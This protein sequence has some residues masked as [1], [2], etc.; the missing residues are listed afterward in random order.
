[1]AIE[2]PMQILLKFSMMAVGILPL[3]GESDKKTNR[4][5]LGIGV[6]WF[7]SV[8]T[9][10]SI[11]SVLTGARWIVEPVSEETHSLIGKLTF[12]PIFFYRMIVCFFV[13]ITLTSMSV[14]AFIL[15]TLIT[16]IVLICVQDEY[17]NQ[18]GKHALL[19]LI[20]PIPNLP[21]DE[22]IK[23]EH[24][25]RLKTLFW[26]VLTGNSMFLILHSLIYC[27]YHFDVFNPWIYNCELNVLII[28]EQV[29]KNINPLMITL[30]V[31]ATVPVLLSY[32]LPSKG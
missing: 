29:Y 17:D 23:S 6:G 18:P 22:K 2:A 4:N 31:G 12:V 5:G 16:W 24:N 7:Q 28:K 32:C 3:P 15:F 11:I 21:S 9:C 8:S 25:P 10:L 14:I 27:L 20:F 13:I 26:M 30:F 19:S 1:M